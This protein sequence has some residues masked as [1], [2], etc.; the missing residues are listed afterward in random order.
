MEITD[1]APVAVRQRIRGRAR[2]AGRLATVRDGDRAR[3]ERLLA[4]RHPEHSP[5]HSPEHSTGHSP[6][7]AETDPAA[8]MLVR[9]ETGAVSVDDLWGTGCVTPAALGAAE[10]DPVARHEAELLQ[11]L[12]SAH[13]DRVRGLAGLLGERGGCAGTA[14]RDVVP[15]A[16]DR[17]GLRLRCTTGGGHAFDARL[18]FPEPVGS[19]AELRYAMHTLFAAAGD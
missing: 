17:F 9:L 18:D 13:G 6:G 11:H 19:T 14:V 4:E 10:P 1:V 3:C 5:G 8:W 12:H 7:N 15:L 2:L 16:L